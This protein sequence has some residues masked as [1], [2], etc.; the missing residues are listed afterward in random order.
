MPRFRYLLPL[1]S[2]AALLALAAPAQAKPSARDA[3]AA[4]AEARA[5]VAASLDAARSGDVVGAAERIAVARKLQARAARLARRAGT[6]RKPA[7]RAM[8]LKSAAS[9]VDDAFDSYAALIA[10]APPELQPYLLEALT[11]LEDLRAELLARLTAFVDTLPADVREQILAAITAFQSDGDL[12]ALVGAL[13]GGELVTAVQAGLQ[14]LV[15]D[16]T[17]AIGGQLGELG[18]LAELLPPDALAQLQTAMTQIQEQLE[19]AL[20]QLAALLAP[21]SS[22]GGAPGV[23]GIPGVLVGI[24]E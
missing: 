18:Q 17:A 7:K 16:L 24:C 23:P 22:G 3:R 15:T 5:A 10:Q 2:L 19:S 12:Q 6:D 13:S 4:T 11:Q 20:A 1:L 8:L 9:G 14:Q 21:P